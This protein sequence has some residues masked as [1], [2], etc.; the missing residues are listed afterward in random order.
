MVSTSVLNAS[1]IAI[2]ETSSVAGLSM[3]KSSVSSAA[4]VPK[5]IKT[6]NIIKI[7]IN[8]LPCFFSFSPP[9]TAN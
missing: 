7:L 5:Q 3:V 1:S 8:S 9:F 2:C 4:T 6:L